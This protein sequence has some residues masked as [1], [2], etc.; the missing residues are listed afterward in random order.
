[1]LALTACQTDPEW[2]NKEALKIGA[3]LT[4]AAKIRERQT[5]SFSVASEAQL[6][7]ETTQVLQDLGFTIEESS[8]HYGV[9][10]GSKNRD[11][12]EA[13]EVA[14]QVALAVGLALMGVHYTPSWDKDQVIRA[15]VTTNPIGQHEVRLRVSF[16]RIV[17]N[18]QHLSRVEELTAPE[19]SQGFFDKVR[20]GLAQDHTS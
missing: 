5:Q 12:T 17:T 16:E 7:S 20:S 19:F 3:P 6:L 2:A 18:T 4:D 15:T 14:G 9:L 10:E 13:G 8:A 1:L 11:A